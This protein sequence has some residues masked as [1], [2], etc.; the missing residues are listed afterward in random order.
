MSV[1]DV[2]VLAGTTITFRVWI[3][4]GHKITTLQPYLQDYNWAWTSSL[5]W[6]FHCQRLE[7]ADP[8]GAG[9]RRSA[10]AA[11]RHSVYDQ[12]RLDEHLLH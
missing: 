9:D 3:P 12:R 8:D 10:I 4:S 7:H 1:G 6:K 11:A 5:V 2:A